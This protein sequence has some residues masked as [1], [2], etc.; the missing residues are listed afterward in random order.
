MKDKDKKEKLIPIV[1]RISKD[2]KEEITKLA[3][4]Q[5]IWEEDVIRNGIE[6]ELNLQRYK[7]NLDFIIKEL[8]RMIDAKLKPF[9][10]SQRKINAKYL[11]TSAIN[12]YLQGEV[13]SRLLGD[14]M[15]KEFVNILSNARKKANYYITHDAEGMD[16]KDLYDFYEIGE[17]YRDEDRK[18]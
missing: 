3:I 16:K 4:T 7:D 9:I 11:R 12:T 6:K 15:H 2:K 14:D 10:N 1:V 5:G 18:E 8:D 17:I 13:L